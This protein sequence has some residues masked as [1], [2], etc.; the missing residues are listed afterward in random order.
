LESFR[1]TI[2]VSGSLAGEIS[3]LDDPATYSNGNGLGAITCAQLLHKVFDV[4]LHCLFGDK[5][6]LGDVA[7]AITARNLVED[8]NLAY[9][10]G[11]VAIM[12]RQMG[13]NFCRN[14]LLT[15]VHLANHFYEFSGRHAFE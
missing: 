6:L 5:E 2:E 10:E 14:P 15:R 11:L 1:T 3:E 13:R 4:H 8:F 7:L 12:L 9:R